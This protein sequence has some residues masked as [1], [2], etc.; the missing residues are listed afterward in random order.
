MSIT[1]ERMIVIG[2]HFLGQQLAT[3]A[4][5]CGLDV[6]IC[7]A[8]KIDTDPTM[9]SLLAQSHVVEEALSNEIEVKQRLWQRTSKH[10]LLNTYLRKYFWS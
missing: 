10:V 3:I 8:E 5:Q 7:D 9:A 2:N 6:K 1:S 4:C